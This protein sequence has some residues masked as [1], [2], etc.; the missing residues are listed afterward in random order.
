VAGALFLMG[1]RDHTLWDYHEPYVGGIILEMTTSGNWV[2]TNDLFFEVGHMAVV[3]M[4]LTAAVSFALGLASWLDHPRL[5]RI[6][7]PGS[8]AGTGW[9]ALECVPGPTLEAR[10]KAR[11]PL[12]APGRPRIGT[13]SG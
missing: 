7:E 3:D 5:V 12:P 8:P 2:A 6:L 4:T 11:G 13:A 1:L 10:L 9:L